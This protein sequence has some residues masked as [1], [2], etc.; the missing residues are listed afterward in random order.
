MNNNQPKKDII[1]RSTITRRE[2]LKLAAVTAGLVAA[3]C[4]PKW[5]PETPG[6]V[7]LPVSKPAALA[8]VALAQAEN[9][10][11][12]L[13]KQ[14][15]QAML[16][17]IGGL[18]DVVKP[19]AK[20]AIKV[21]LTGG[22]YFQPPAGFSAPESYVTH[23]EVVRA[24]GE[25]VADA[26]ARELYIVEAVYDQDSYP[27]W[28]YEA[29]A[30]D[31]GATLVD[32]NFP[33]PYHDFALTPS[34]KDWFIYENFFFNPIL[35]EIDAF[36]SVSKMKCHYNCGITLSMKNLV[37]LVPYGRYRLAEDHWW[38]SALHGNGD[39][40]NRRLPRVILDLNRARP[41]HLALVDGIMTAEGGEA[42]R[43]SFAPVQPG[44]LVAG[45]NALAT[46]AV[47]TAAMGFDPTIQPPAPPFIRS[48]NYLEMGR[49]LGLGTNRLKEIEV[50]GAQID[51]VQYPFEPSWEM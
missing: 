43:G 28:G 23:P 50:I 38:R 21:N 10:E 31:L 18:D 14:K 22:M 12:V 36:I 15:V 47:A 17:G 2:F 27:A 45:K 8:Q 34:G 40:A 41:I 37:G 24:V 30:K 3:G 33:A 35:N 25:L 26:G 7:T 5:L 4:T 20:V 44:L 39:E 16:E 42:P 11:R 49:E 9:Y 6:Q 13:I 29:V 1:D 48:D 32:L 46:D 19:G 51:E